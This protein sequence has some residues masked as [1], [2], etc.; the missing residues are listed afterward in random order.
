MNKSEYLYVGCGNHRMKG[1]THADISVYKA[2]KKQTIEQP[3]II[4]DITKK[5]PLKNKDRDCSG[6]QG[7][8]EIQVQDKI[9]V[10]AYSNKEFNVDMYK[11]DTPRYIPYV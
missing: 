5:I 4:C 9:N 8:D 1:F 2:Y 11:M 7:C 3:E 10:S 6:D